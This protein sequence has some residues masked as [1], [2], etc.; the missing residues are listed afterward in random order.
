[1]SSAE[2]DTL[3]EQINAKLTDVSAIELHPVTDYYP[4]TGLTFGAI[5][6]GRKGESGKSLQII[7]KEVYALNS[8]QIVTLSGSPIQIVVRKPMTNA[9]SRKATEEILTV[10]KDLRSTGKIESKP[11]KDVYN[12]LYEKLSYYYF[13]SEP[14][15]YI[16]F[17]CWTIATYMFII[18]PV[19]P[20][21]VLQGLRETGKSTLAI[22]LRL[23]SWNPT[24]I[25]SSIR[26]APMF[27]KIE[28]ERPTYIVD[29]TRISPN[30]PDVEELFEVIERGG[31]VPRC[32]GE[33][34]KVK[35]FEVYSPK[36]CATRSNVTFSDKAIEVICSAPP[37]DIRKD[38]DKRRKTMLYDEDIKLF[39]TEI[40]KSV[41]NNWEKVLNAYKEIEQTEKLT[42]RRYTLW[43]PFL[44]VCKVYAPQH[45]DDLLALAEEESQRFGKGDLI[46][47]IEDTILGILREFSDDT[48]TVTLP[49]KSIT[50]DVQDIL[51]REVVRN[52]RLV[53]GALKNLG[54]VK[55]SYTA[56]GF[57]RLEIDLIKA[58]SVASERN[59]QKSF[60]TEKHEKELMFCVLCHKRMGP[61]KFDIAYVPLQWAKR[62]DMIHGLAHVQCCKNY[63]D[64]E[65][66]PCE[67]M[68]LIGGSHEMHPRKVPT[69]D[70]NENLDKH[71][72]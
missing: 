59:V 35:E 19:F 34:N 40:L 17:N 39:R 69:P 14:R 22:Y 9:I 13:S 72:T 70:P 54:I 44:A 8:G 47:D 18:F 41:I 33:E 63:Y 29:A 51:G 50:S 26:I 16:L 10:L 37:K 48:S 43:L 49:L 30:S 27:R 20:H 53:S 15:Y 68:L 60:V 21:I 52:Y 1:V 57:R 55:K 65:G 3:I 7:H 2:V 58:R 46:T 62:P 6:A 23:T 12:F 5:V 11:E 56:G 45:Y 4:E 38:Y 64:S 61:D 66:F 32:V 24:P 25:Q 71:I 31:K 67:W 36:V 42:G 28:S